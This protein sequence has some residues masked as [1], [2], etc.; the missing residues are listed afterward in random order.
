MA[1]IVAVVVEQVE[2]RERK[3]KHPAPNQAPDMSPSG[4][5]SSTGII[6]SGP[7]SF[8]FARPATFNRAVHTARGWA[9]LRSLVSTYRTIHEDAKTSSSRDFA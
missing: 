6:E 5:R 7:G 2:G 9:L 4:V 3:A 1:G 8:S